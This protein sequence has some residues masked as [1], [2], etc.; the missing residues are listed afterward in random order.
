MASW[1]G[2]KQQTAA[3]KDEVHKR[4]GLD[5]IIEEW[6]RSASVK[7]ESPEWVPHELRSKQE[8]VE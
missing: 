6:D 2:K 7:D 3:L 1:Y 4:F 5:T 8:Q